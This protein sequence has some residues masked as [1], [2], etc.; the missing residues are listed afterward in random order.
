M[1]QSDNTRGALLMMASMAAF[2]LNDTFFKSVAGNVPFFQAILIRGVPTCVLLALAAW[3]SGAFKIAIPA[4]DWRTIGLRTFGELGATICFLIALFN[5]PIA[6]VTAIL[7]TLPLA[8]TLVGAVFFGETVGWRRYIAI[9]IGFGGMLLIVR[10]GGDGFDIYA[11][12]ALCAVGFVVIRDLSTRRLSRAIPSMV[13]ALIAAAAITTMGGI[14]TLLSGW[15][16]VA[17]LSVGKLSMAS[18][19]IIGGYLLSVMVM[20]VGEIAV[21]SPFR[22]TALIWA[23]LL[24]M[25]AFGEFPDGLTLLGSAIVVG[26]G[27]YTFYRERQVARLR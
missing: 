23:I 24:G 20:R 17:L 15:E 19:F 10:P 3:F 25:I 2:A 18:I 1:P 11:L 16:P 8:I 26:M 6:N 14:G 21:V 12:L 9:L 22:Y 27:V 5:M 13:V 4:A 7:Q